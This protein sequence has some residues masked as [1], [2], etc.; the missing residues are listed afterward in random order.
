[1]GAGPQPVRQ[2]DDA[3]RGRNQA[4]YS[5]VYQNVPGGILN[6]ITGGVEDEHDIAFMPPEQVA[7]GVTWR[8][9]EQWIPHTAWFLLAA[10]AARQ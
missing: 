7:A 6:G 10:S 2:L 1:V 8:R 3:G 9:A 4:E 5:A